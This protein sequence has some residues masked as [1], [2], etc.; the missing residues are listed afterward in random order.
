VTD[1]HSFSE[2]TVVIT[3]F[4]SVH[5]PYPLQYD[6]S[7]GNRLDV[8]EGI[9]LL[10]YWHRDDAF[11]GGGAIQQLPTHGVLSTRANGAFTYLPDAGFAGSDSFTAKMLTHLSATTP[12]GDLYSFQFHFP[13]L[14]TITVRNHPPHL[15]GDSYSTPA[16]EMLTVSASDG[17]LANDHDADGHP[18]RLDRLLNGP[19]GGEILSWS[20]DGSFSYMSDAGFSG[21]DSFEYQV[22]DGFGG[23]SKRTVS[24]NVSANRRP[25]FL[26]GLDFSNARNLRS[27]SSRTRWWG[28][29]IGST[30]MATR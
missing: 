23:V 17:L 30:A 14:V 27:L 24:V 11:Y 15:N 28:P 6:V 8:G 21:S 25:I 19:T 1:G 22:S 13:R 3:V 29:L 7:A 12:S 18:L 10:S 16:E 4:D 20:E 26:S 9:G 2:A 5:R